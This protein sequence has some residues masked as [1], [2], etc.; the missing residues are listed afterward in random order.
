MV[1]IIGINTFLQLGNQL[2]G[3][4]LGDGFLQGLGAV[5]NQILGVLQAQ[6][7]SGTDD[8]NN[9]QLGSAGGLQDDVEFG[10]FFS[11]R[12]SGSSRSRSG[13]RWRRSC[14]R[15]HDQRKV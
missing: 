6:T 5:V 10:L 4:F 14:L 13:R 15:D 12:G 2:L 7:G 8:L 1:I 3:I 11:G 9:A